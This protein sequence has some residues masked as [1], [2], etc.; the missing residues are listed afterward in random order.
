MPE[1]A[2]DWAA[3]I[4]DVAEFLRRA[5]DMD[6][7]VAVD[8]LLAGLVKCPR[9]PWIWLVLET[10]Y[11]SR[12][13]DTAWFS[14]GGHWNPC[15]FARLQGRT[16]WHERR[17]EVREWLEGPIDERLFV[18][19]WYEDYPKF[20]IWAH[21]D[22]LLHRSLRIRT[23]TP[24]TR[25]ALGR[26]D[27]WQEELDLDQLRALVANALNDEA[28]WRGENP[29]S[30]EEPPHFLY[31]TELLQRLAPWFIDWN[32]LVQ[33]LAWLAIRHAHLYG[34]TETGPEEERMLQRVM[35]DSIPPW[36]AKAIEALADGP[37]KHVSL[38]RA[39]EFTTRSIWDS[40]RRELRRLAQNGLIEY[41]LTRQSYCLAEP[42]RAGLLWIVRGEAF[43]ATAR[44]ARVARL[45]AL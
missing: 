24:R 29:P 39:M 20:H 21:A 17:T 38:E 27:Q 44:G 12:D 26:L 33:N 45:G 32:T 37:R 4:D 34:R 6:D 22:Q 15:S 42:H 36:I 1:W 19:N 8:V 14:F 30:F 7:R 41:N 9:T 16:Y 3:R 18:E 5:F 23:L 43:S 35:A 31:Y 40:G 11:A 10:N 28:G 2:I 13:C 25:S